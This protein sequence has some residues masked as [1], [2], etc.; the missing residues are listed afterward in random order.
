MVAHALAAEPIAKL[1]RIRSDR[2]ITTGLEIK[3][4][5]QF[6]IK[7]VGLIGRHSDEFIADAWILDSNTR[8]TVWVMERDNT[9]R[10]GRDG[11]REANDKVNLNPGK[12]ELYYY[13][14]SNWF[15]DLQ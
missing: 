1:D 13:A 8:K 6:N 10:K 2:V 9:E 3:K 11:L 5:G 15:G 7:A 14:G 4:G 12:Y